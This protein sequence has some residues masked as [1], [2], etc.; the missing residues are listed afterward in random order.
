M[1]ASFVSINITSNNVLLNKNG[2]PILFY[3]NGL[4]PIEKLLKE[5]ELFR[6]YL[7]E[8]V[9]NDIFYPDA[10]IN[11]LYYNTA[12][13]TEEEKYGEGHIDIEEMFPMCEC[14]NMI[15]TYLKG[16]FGYLYTKVFKEKYSFD[17]VFERDIIN[18]YD[19]L[20]AKYPNRVSKNI[21]VNY[22]SSELQQ[23][24]KLNAAS[25]KTI[26]DTLNNILINKE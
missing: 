19:K 12:G 4:E 22:I 1:K 8:N 3:W 13:E 17:D 5:S 23:R 2:I 26:L 6:N 14:P 25:V 20:L 18:I 24:T 11:Y 7:N 21:I 16:Y 9:M 10:S 15:N